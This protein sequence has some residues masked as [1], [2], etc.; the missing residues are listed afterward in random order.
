MDLQ[1]KLSK[2]INQIHPSPIRKIVTKA[3]AA[4]KK[5]IKI[6]DFSVGRS[7]PGL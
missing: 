3:E 4:K 1:K 6:S 5:G 2:K 7:G